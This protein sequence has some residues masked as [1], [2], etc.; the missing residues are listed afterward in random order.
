MIERQGSATSKRHREITIFRPFLQYI[1]LYI[2]LTAQV[3]YEYFDIHTITPPEATASA[4][5][6]PS[7][8]KQPNEFHLDTET[9][10]AG[11][12]SLNDPF[13]PAVGIYQ[14]QTV[15]SE[16]Q[17]SQNAS[18]RFTLYALPHDMAQCVP[19]IP[20]P[21]SL[22]D[23]IYRTARLTI[24]VTDNVQA[25]LP[26]D[27]SEMQLTQI[28]VSDI[29]TNRN[30]PVRLYRCANDL[31]SVVFPRPGIYQVIY[32]TASH[33]DTL[34]PKSADF[35]RGAPRSAPTL[36]T[37]QSSEIAALIHATP[38]LRRIQNAQDPLVSLLRY[39]QAFHSEPLTDKP[40][41]GQ[42]LES[43]ILK[44]EKGL[45]RHRAL[46]FMILS[47][48]MGYETRIVGN[49]VHAFAEI[50]HNGRWYPAELG[51]QARSLTI[52]G[53]GKDGQVQDNYDFAQSSTH[54]SST[55][56]APIPAQ[57]KDFEFIPSEVPGRLLRD[58]VLVL[59]GQMVNIYKSPIAQTKFIY[60]LK[61]P[62]RES[63]RV[64]AIT[65]E[66]GMIRLE[67]RIPADWPLG[68]SEGRWHRVK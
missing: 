59:H 16:L 15:F 29:E 30:Q 12:L 38:A 14:R 24:D 32:E 58:K 60:E 45:C 4:T 22:P 20:S 63:R 13:L 34:P 35:F 68:E 50:Y 31:Y 7:Q 48:Y 53:W 10:T 54:N 40:R 21:P 51:G 49:S 2:L 52:N 3:P 66:Q 47:R 17:L 8:V 28:Q 42:S 25:Y 56:E 23:A 67:M 61:H 57:I 26:G 65:D 9:Q 27:S 19:Y 5:A 37:T 55:H 6:L 43:L 18:S 41:P 44:E 33:A 36:P 1:C 39:F 64:S 62:Q 11:D 46:L